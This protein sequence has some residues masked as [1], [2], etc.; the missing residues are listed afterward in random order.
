[1]QLIVFVELEEEEVTAKEKLRG[2]VDERWDSMHDGEVHT[3]R[4]SAFPRKATIGAT[5]A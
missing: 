5:L 1:M 3:N 2:E 4:G